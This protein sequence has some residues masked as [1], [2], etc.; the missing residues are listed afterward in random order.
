M[1]A[2][3][4]RGLWCATLTPLTARGDVDLARLA[5]HV[6]RLFAAGVDGVAPFGT[7]GEGPSFSP[8]ERQAGLDSLLAAGIAPTRVLA[9]TG[10]ADLPSTVALS[11]QAVLAGCA[12]C[13]VLPP[14]FFKGVPD[15]GVHA[16]YAQ[17][18]EHV[19]DVRLRLYLY[20]LPQV[21]GV[22]ISASLAARLA[23]DFPGTIG[24]VKDSGGDFAHTQA[25]IDALPGAAILVGHEPHL[26]RLMRAGGAGTVCGVANLDPA[27]VRALLRPD[28]STQD[29]N[30]MRALL[31][32]LFAFSLVPA[33]KATL[34]AL[35]SDDAWNAVRPPLAAL[36]EPERDR[37]RSMLRD[38]R[39]ATT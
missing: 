1:N 13:L 10:C 31:D 15:D 9:A 35:R 27:L 14:F 32:V 2:D 20:N 3:G 26:P 18:I 5:D 33:M 25:L 24:G 36:D 11:R 6:K 17:L 7:T 38:I 23:R 29:E 19:G 8:A 16:W 30:A 39:L 22:T 21:S 28:A 37:L 12:G 4:I 34:A